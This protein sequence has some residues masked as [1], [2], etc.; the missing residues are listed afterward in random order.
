LASRL[1]DAL[2]VEVALRDLFAQPTL[3]G[4]A[5]FVA[6]AARSTLS[7]IRAGSAGTPAVLS[8]SQQRLWFLDQ[9]DRNASVAYHMPAGLHLR[10]QLDRAALRRTLD[11]LVARH[12]GLR[13]RF[14]SIDGEPMQAIDA[15]CGFALVEH[16]LSALDVPDRDAEVARIARAEAIAPFDLATGPLIRGRLLRL[17]DDEHVLLVTQHHIVS[18]GW[19]IAVLVRE[20]GALYAAFR[21]GRPDPLP[22][23]AIRYAD[24]A[25]WQREWLQGDVLQTQVDF[26]RDHLAGAPAL[27]EL[28]ADR[29]RPVVQSYQGGRVSVAL[30]AARTAGLRALAHRHGATPFMVLLAAWS[31]LLS[32]VSGQTDLVVGTPVANRQR[33]EVE[34]LIG[35]FVN[36]LALRVQLHDD[37]SVAALLAQV[38]ATMLAAQ[39]HQDLPFEQVVEAIKP[40]RSLGHSPIFQVMLSLDN[41]PNDALA[42]PG[43]TLTPMPT[44]RDTTQFDLSLSLTD[45]G[46]TIAG[47]LEYASDLFDADTIER[48]ADH[49]FSLLDGLLADD[50]SR[51]SRLP[52]LTDAQR[53]QL[54]VDFNDT[55][56]DYPQGR[57]IHE[58]FEAQAAAQPDAIALVHG[59]QSLT[60]DALNRRANRV[61]HRLLALG[62]RPDDRVAIGVERGLDMVVGLLGILKAGGAYVPLDPAYPAERLEYMLRDS[63]PV[64][65]LTQRSLQERFS[66]TQPTL[67]LDAIDWHDAVD[68]GN[69]HVPDLRDD[70]LA[71]LIYTSG[72]T[73]QPKGVMVEHR[74]VVRL[75]LCREFDDLD[76]TSVVAQVS[77]VSFDAATYEIWGTLLKGGR[78]VHV[79]TDCLIDPARLAA[80]LRADGI[81]VFWVTTAVFNRIAAQAPDCL[82]A[83]DT[84]GF[85]GEAASPAAVERIVRHGK[86]RRLFNYYGPTENTTFST[87]YEIGTAT[88]DDGGTLPI[89][90]SLAWTRTYVLDDAMQPVPAGVI[91]ELYVGGPGVARGYLGRPALTAER[92]VA[93]PFADGERLYRTGDLVRRLRDGNLRFVGRNDGQVKLRGFRI[94]TGEI[95]ARLVACAGVRD[96]AVVLREDSPGDKRLVA[97]VVHDADS[98]VRHADLRTA[99]AA[100]LP[101]YMVPAAF[102]RLDALPLTPNGKLD[103]RALPMPDGSAVVARDYAA[104]LPGIEST[105][106][107]TWQAL[108]GLERVGRDD[109]FFE[110]G[111]HSLLVVGLIERLRREG[112]AA[113][114]RTVFAAPTLSALA[115]AI[116]GRD[117]AANV[118]VP[119][120]R[121][122]VGCT[123]LT[124]DL[125]PL[126][127]LDQ[128]QIDAIVAATDGGAA[129]IQD[130]Y[131][132]SPLQEGILFHHLLETRGDAY[133]LRSVVAFDSRARLDAFVH[134]VQAVID[135]HD[136]LRSSLRWTGLAQPVQVVHR[137]APLPLVELDVRDGDAL[138]ALL[139]HTDPRE[140]ALDLTRAPLMAASVAF[141]ASTGEWLLSLVHHHI[142]CDH[143]T[144][145]LMLAE[146]R[147]LLDDRADA[148]PPSL[149]YRDFIAQTASMPVA[150]YEA[151]FRERL[152]DV[153]EPTAPFG[154]LDV[155]GDGNGIAE[156]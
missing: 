11:A 156:A 148:L 42:L 33:A 103:R 35:L 125:L 155:Q 130:V 24:Y 61:A 27:L 82:A 9:L 105:L 48:H 30:D 143:V 139:A 112:I 28:P 13:T 89:G 147:A 126:V 149:P 10:G 150:Q 123:A 5:Q 96:A 110:L 98:D 2:G 65:L 99:L 14:V 113:D 145:E 60:Y 115:A 133:L 101:E 64:A 117:A 8:F 86:P 92:F 84:V 93:N 16:D 62:V 36:T 73:G 114:V 100:A 18:D 72:S 38:K 104:P 6:H 4:F 55:A 79:D 141:D 22:T 17:A 57:L 37:P 25:A 129:N 7:A 78:L 124:P 136:I 39:A 70:H 59:S 71:Y 21:E 122:P 128:A 134:A 74:N 43:L 12:D 49:F 20:L 29:P 120:N 142:V 146:V 44:P 119:P 40:A 68:D 102:V 138:D 131:P 132:L 51:V 116:A 151:Y 67:V 58:L 3:A 94:E 137:R 34:P 127:T 46:D 69:P 63:A 45:A 108:L 76:A 52:L 135:R 26:W 109:H 152:G 88:V 32:R 85:G 121:I 47:Y 144:L 97:Y 56:V 23:L 19:S 1:R 53:R 90:T 15:A 87:R 80:Q 111:G 107:R 154:V 81:G 41:T 95:E 118:D 83:L 50:Q 91:G 75:A 140:V 66:T 31:A 77:N 54:L 153:T 106:A